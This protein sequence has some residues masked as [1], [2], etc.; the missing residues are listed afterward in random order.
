VSSEEE[1]KIDMDFVELPKLKTKL[2]GII[3]DKKN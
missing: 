1:E 2:S 3:R